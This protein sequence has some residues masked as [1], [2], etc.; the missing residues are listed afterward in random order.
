MVLV[1]GDGGIVVVVVVVLVVLVVVVL[2]LLVVVQLCC[3]LCCWLWCSCVLA[4]EKLVLLALVL[5]WCWWWWRTQVACLPARNPREPIANNNNTTTNNT[6]NTSSVCPSVA[7]SFTSRSMMC[8]HVCW[9]VA[10]N[11]LFY[12]GSSSRSPTVHL[13]AIAWAFSLRSLVRLMP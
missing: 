3:W 11:K 8:A 9:K 2:V 6:T 5:C 12:S 13:E 1:V 10:A 7:T 4:V